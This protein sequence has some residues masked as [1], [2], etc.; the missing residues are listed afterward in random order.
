ML[1]QG[2][3][4]LYHR[5]LGLDEG[6]VNKCIMKDEEERLRE[7]EEWVNTPIKWHLIIR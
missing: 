1:K 3:V 7:F 4:S 6:E 2:S 5:H